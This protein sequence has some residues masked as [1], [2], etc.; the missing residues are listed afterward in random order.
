MTKYP[1]LTNMLGM[2]FHSRCHLREET[3]SL[4]SGRALTKID[5]RKTSIIL[6]D[7]HDQIK[8]QV[9]S[10]DVGNPRAYNI[11]T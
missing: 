9:V 7:W 6:E 1:I 4:G 3:F 2:R 10:V 8:T 11:I 5:E